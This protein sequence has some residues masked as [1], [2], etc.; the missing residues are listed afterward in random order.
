[1]AEDKGRTCIFDL[2]MSAKTPLVAEW[3]KMRFF[4]FL[5]RVGIMENFTFFDKAYSSG[6]L[7]YNNDNWHFG[8]LHCLV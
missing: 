1:M 3:G 7:G 6:A 5:W 2:V 4:D 8:S